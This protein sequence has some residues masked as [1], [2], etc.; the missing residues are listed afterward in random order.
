MYSVPSPHKDFLL[1]IFPPA[2]KVISVHTIEIKFQNCISQKITPRLQNVFVDYKNV[3]AYYKMYAIP[4]PH[5]DFL[6]NS[7]PPANK[8]ISV[9]T[10]EIKFL[11]CISQKITPRLQNVF[12]DYK[13]YSYTT[14]CIRFH[15]HIKISF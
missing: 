6:L 14:K 15:R 5:K 11:N 8:V 3:F 13:M 9:H 4:S 2:N 1:N 10:I 12:V 7:F